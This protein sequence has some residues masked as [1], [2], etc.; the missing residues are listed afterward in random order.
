MIKGMDVSSLLEVEACGGRFF[1]GE[2]QE[3]ALTILRRKGANL[4]RLRIWNDPRSESGESYGAGGNDLEAAL[5]LA[6]RA[7]TLGMPWMADFH[8]SD[9]W[10]DPGKQRIPKAWRHL[11]A[12]DMARA[13]YR[14]T[15]DCLL[16]MKKRDLLPAFVAVGNELTNGLL[17]P[18]GRYPDF[19]GIVRFLNAGIR[20]VRE[21][22]PASRVLLHLD[23]GSSNA[24][25]RAWFDGYL[26]AGGADF[27]VIG[28]SYYP[29]WHGKLAGM[30]ENLLDLSRRYGKD[31]LIAETAAGF[32]T[33]DYQQYERLPDGQ[34]KGPWDPEKKGKTLEYPL[35]REGQSAFLADLSQVIRQVP[36]GRCLG[37]VYWEPAW[38]PVPGSEWAKPCALPYIE[39]QGPGGNE[40]ANQC[41]FD[42]DGRPLP[43][44]E[45]LHA[46]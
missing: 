25:Y 38:L 31:L 7:Q 17:W 4:V 12:E 24:L 35:T 28:L 23:N 29:F 19:A 11:N 37:F 6:K 14:F 44:L 46:L 20:A 33:E 43:A 15:R 21:I 16:E 27:D 45:Q 32:T 36:G 9:F 2:A 5:V 42:Y 1:D 41:L 22:A 34:R 40:Q 3:D 26:N 39:E 30:R 10:A 8:Y 18:L 13:L